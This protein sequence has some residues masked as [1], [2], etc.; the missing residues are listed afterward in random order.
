MSDGGMST[1]GGFTMPDNDN[2]TNAPIN[3]T[4]IDNA[5]VNLGKLG[6]IAQAHG[7]ILSEVHNLVGPIQSLL[8][9][10]R[11]QVAKR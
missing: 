5:L 9:E 4:V 3:A 11:S 8:V 1:R 6:G 7:I 10:M 2:V